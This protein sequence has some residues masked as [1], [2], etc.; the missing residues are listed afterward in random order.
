MRR[1]LQILH[2]FCSHAC[3]ND[4]PNSIVCVPDEAPSEQQIL[5]ACHWHFGFTPLH[6][7]DC[8]PLLQILIGEITPEL[9]LEVLQV[10]LLIKLLHQRILF[11]QIRLPVQVHC[12]HIHHA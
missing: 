11:L 8:V 9:A 2:D 5:N 12:V 1:L 7:H 3:V 6:L 10:L 4:N